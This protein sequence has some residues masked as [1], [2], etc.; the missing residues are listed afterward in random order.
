MGGR[1]V[2]LLIVV[3]DGG[4][5]EGLVDSARGMADAAGWDWRMRCDC[6]H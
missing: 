3:G 6:C 4:A 1:T 2:T 5:E